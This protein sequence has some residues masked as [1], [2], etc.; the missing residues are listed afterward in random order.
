ME[1]GYNLISTAAFASVFF[2]FVALVSTYY[3]A[4]APP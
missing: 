1:S 3:T 2:V 4:K